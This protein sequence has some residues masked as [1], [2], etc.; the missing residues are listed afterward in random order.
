MKNTFTRLKNNASLVMLIALAAGILMAGVWLAPRAVASRA[1][2]KGK[3]SEAKEV[4]KTPEWLIRARRVR[5]QMNRLESS[6]R[7]KSTGAIAAP[8]NEFPVREIQPPEEFISPFDFSPD[9]LFK[10]IYGQT[11][12][13]P[14]EAHDEPREAA[15]H[16]TRKRLPEGEKELPVEKYFE[17]QERMRGMRYFSS[18]LGRPVS[19]RENF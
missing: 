19:D 11:A 6:D 10:Y 9:R 2:E 8:S 5:R 12:D 4:N 1:E 7:K 14:L 16:F 18:A 17:A 15:R 3:K 13:N